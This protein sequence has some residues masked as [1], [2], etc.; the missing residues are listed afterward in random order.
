LIIE[1]TKGVPHLKS[2]GYSFFR[3]LWNFAIRG[4][5]SSCTPVRPPH[6]RQ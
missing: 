2:M 3:P 4:G 1:N 5:H 6:L